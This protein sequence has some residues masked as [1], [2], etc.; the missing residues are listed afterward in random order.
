VNQK[1]E[2]RTQAAFFRVFACGVLCVAA[3]SSRAAETKAARPP[4][5]S[6]E[7]EKLLAPATASEPSYN[8]RCSTKLPAGAIVTKRLIFE[9]EKA[10]RV[11]FDCNNALVTV[12]AVNT[13]GDMIQIKS[14]KIMANGTGTWER[15]EDITIRNCR[16]AGSV[17]L[18]GMSR[19]AGGEDMKASSRSLGHT[20][21]VQAAAPTRITLDH[22]TIEGVVSSEGVARI[23]L[24][25]AAGVTHSSLLY[26]EI[27]G[28]SDSVAI[29]LDAESALNT[30]K[31]NSIHT[32][33][34][35]AKPR[36]LIALDG[37]ARNKII[38][39]DFASLANG[40]IFLYRNCGEES[41]VRHQSPVE[42]QIIN[43]VFHFTEHDRGNPAVFVASRNGNR[44]YCGDDRG[45][46]F[47]SSR[48][49]RDFAKR[50]VIA[51]NQIYLFDPSSAIV[52]QDEPNTVMDNVKIQS[53]LQRRAGCFLANA[54]PTPFML[55]GKSTQLSMSGDQVICRDVLQ[56]CSDG[57]LV[58]STRGCGQQRLPK[59]VAFE[60]RL[61]GSNATCEG[62]VRCEA[63]TRI[64]GA[65]AACNLEYGA[66]TSSII[67]SIPMNRVSVVNESDIS[68]EGSCKVGD[69][70]I[71]RG[72]ASVSALRGA[73]GFNFSCSERDKNGGDCHVKGQVFCE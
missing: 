35:R 6:S 70:G 57:E 28:T 30:I 7:I 11:D 56:T 53:P 36:E 2:V 38:D 60:C 67:N 24:Y 65:R 51:Q 1:I 49:D 39:N 17:R 43:N 62:S 58:K 3:S 42:N 52:V 45:Y 37:S 34:G 31:G 40:G 61:E 15:P 25:F 66:V 4:C 63:G 23:P 64:I 54:Y 12:G 59:V 46:P 47:G 68:A 18:I 22:L 20:A 41:V 29:Y 5:A 32:A 69:T 14:R 16:V 71:S 13:G 72:I 8:V 55:D 33:T 19:N 73:A 48:D 44:S 27:K 21:R 9:G 10:S 50:N 26:S